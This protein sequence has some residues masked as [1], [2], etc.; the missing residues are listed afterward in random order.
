VRCVPTPAVH[1]LDRDRPGFVID[2][3]PAYTTVAVHYDAA[4]LARTRGDAYAQVCAEL[5]RCISRYDGVPVPADEGRLVEI[6]VRYGGADGPDLDDVA[7]V[8]SLRPDDVV[9]M[10]AGCEYRV[11]MIGF[12]PGFPYL[13]G[14]PR[15]LAMPRRAV[16][17]THV[18]AGSVG[19]AGGQTGIYPL[20]TPGGWQIIGRTD[21]QLFRPSADPPTLLRLGDRVRFTVIE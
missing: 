20:A 18:P 1:A 2:I 17:R 10:H 13:A 19:I 5:G 15:R 12:A 16:P 6:P 7:R 11:Y 14:L 8:T 21:V 9:A 4:T 3:V